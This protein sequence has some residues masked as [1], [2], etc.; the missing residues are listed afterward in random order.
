MA[1]MV[2]LAQDEVPYLAIADAA[3]APGA[4][5]AAPATAPVAPAGVAPATPR[6][7]IWNKLNP[8]KKST[9]KD[10]QENN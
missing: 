6:P 9:K 3:P 2:G 7:S 4:A 10:P 1:E 5:R 8:F